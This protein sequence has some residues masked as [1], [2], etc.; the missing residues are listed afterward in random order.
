MLTDLFD[1]PVLPGLAVASDVVTED[2]ERSLIAAIDATELEPFRFQGWTGKRLTSSFGWHYDFETSQVVARADPIP[3]WLLPIRDRVAAFA[4]LEARSAHP[5]TVDPL[6]SWRRYWLASRPGRSTSMC[7]AS[8][9]AHLLKCA[10]VVAAASATS[11][12]RRY[13]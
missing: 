4:K 3:D 8:R 2:E 10:S 9:S 13:R 11:N 5:G 12:G 6:R 7:W 1:T